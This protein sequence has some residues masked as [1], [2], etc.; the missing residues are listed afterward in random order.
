MY[1]MIEEGGGQRKVQQGDEFLADL[2]DGGSAKPGQKISY[3]K[4][5]F[6]GEGEGKHRIGQPYVAGATVEAEVVEPE[7]TGDKVQV[8]KFRNRT[9]YKRKAGHR[10]RYTRVKVTAIKA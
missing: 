3:T 10:Q 7:V 4:V 8:I 1:A 6:V 5:L 2:V 9:G